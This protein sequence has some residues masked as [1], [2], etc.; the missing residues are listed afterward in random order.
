MLRWLLK[1]VNIWVI[2]ASILVAGGLIIV[3]GLLIFFMPAPVSNAVSPVTVLTVIP[4]PTS[5][6]TLPKVVATH[7]ATPPA[8]ID[9]ISIGSFVQ[10]AGTEGQ[11][12]RIRSGPGIN[13]PPRFL[14]MDSEMFQVKD[15]PKQADG[16]TWWYLE[17]PY[18]PSRSGWAASKYLNVIQS[19]VTPGQ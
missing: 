10:I 14:G 5:T 11:G 12:L 9:G 15:G 4:A 19:T 18:D 1:Q 13:N 16:F 3:I 2:L 17:A 7:T 8:S 6:P